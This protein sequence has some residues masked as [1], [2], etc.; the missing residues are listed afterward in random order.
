MSPA[1]PLEEGVVWHFFSRICAGFQYMHRMRIMH[2]DLKPE[3]V[4]L[5]HDL[6]TVKL[7]DFGLSRVAVFFLIF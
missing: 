6:K 3:N 1:K 4:L 2:R 7:G 5:S